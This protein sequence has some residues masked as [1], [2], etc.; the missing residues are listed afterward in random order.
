MMNPDS[1]LAS[2]IHDYDQP[3]F[4]PCW[5]LDYD[6][7]WFTSCWS[8]PW[9][10]WAL[11]HSVLVVSMKMLNPDSLPLIVSTIRLSPVSLFSGCFHDYA[12]LW[13]TPR[14]LY[15]GY[16]HRSGTWGWRACNQRR[17][18]NIQLPASKCHT[19]L[20]LGGGQKTKLPR[21]HP[22]PSPPLWGLRG[23]NCYVSWRT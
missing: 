6:E 12:E 9:L 5:F 18:L 19:N 16:P 20:Q 11:I 13:F 15:P 4:T 1:L 7:P 8:Y 22:H 10:G 14:W 21:I 3:W 23:P 17:H 2:C